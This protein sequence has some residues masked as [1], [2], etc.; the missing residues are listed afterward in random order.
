[1]E[2]LR[3]AE[4]VGYPP[5]ARHVRRRDR[6]AVMGPMV[7]VVFVFL[8]GA[9]GVMA[10]YFGIIKLPGY[11]MQRKLQE[12][13]GEVTAVDTPEQGDSDELVKARHEGP[14]PAL[15]RIVAGT[16]RG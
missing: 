4:G 9:G 12:R 13:L 14:L 8:L 7:A 16:A 1:P 15:D 6:G 3:T 2:S 11:L 5:A 10:A